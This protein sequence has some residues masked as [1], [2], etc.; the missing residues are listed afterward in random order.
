[1]MMM[2]MIMTTMIMTMIMM[3]L[4]MIM[5]MM[6]IMIM[7]MV[8]VMMMMVMVMMMMMMMMM[9]LIMMMIVI[10]MM[11]MVMIMMMMMIQVKFNEIEAQRFR[12][13]SDLLMDNYSLI[14][15]GSSRKNGAGDGI[16]VSGADWADGDGDS[17]SIASSYQLPSIERSRSR[18]HQM[19][20]QQAGVV[21][22]DYSSDGV[23]H[24]HH[25]HHSHRLS[26][27]PSINN[28]SSTPAA[29]AVSMHIN[30]S[31][32][33]S[34]TG[35]VKTPPTGRHGTITRS[36]SKLS[37]SSSKPD[38]QRTPTLKNVDDLFDMLGISDSDSTRSMKNNNN[39]SSKASKLLALSTR[40]PVYAPTQG[41]L[42]ESETETIMYR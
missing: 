22:G 33:S 8:M 9:L 30:S 14:E 5:M 10:V 17:S 42:K 12:N 37:C 19:E 18:Y 2:M 26:S 38:F 39:S 29:A 27:L 34:S 13:L 32:S 11:V 15:T 16:T 31:S 21:D 28:N 6:M 40:S 35:S 36:P 1:M 24:H 4:M 41:V 23:G 20:D 7:M 25:H 3:L